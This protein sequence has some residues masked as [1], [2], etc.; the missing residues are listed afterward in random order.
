MAEIPERYTKEHMHAY[1]ERVARFKQRHPEAKLPAIDR[2]DLLIVSMAI[3]GYRNGMLLAAELGDIKTFE[4]ICEERQAGRDGWE[5][6]PDIINVE[7]RTE[8]ETPLLCAI[9]RKRLGAA[10]WLLRHGAKVGKDFA[11]NPVIIACDQGCIPALNMFKHY[12]V[13]FNQGYLH[14]TK[15][16]KQVI[17]PLT[18]AMAGNNPKVVQWLVDNGASIDVPLFGKLT[19]RDISKL[20][21]PKEDMSP[22]I[23][24]ILVKQAA[25]TQVPTK[26]ISFW[27]RLVIR[28]IGV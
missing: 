10:E 14:K 3:S 1:R 13:D 8:K 28:Q 6:I 18:V 27:K 2:R 21:V 12:G 20:P 17:Y 9:E 24:E 7:G 5:K 19:A 11:Y 4:Y 16:G 23:K 25:K 15:K 26:P 22:E